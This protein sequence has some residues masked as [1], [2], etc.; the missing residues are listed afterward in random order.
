MS[1]EGMSA[2]YVGA[3][4][5]LGRLSAEE[6]RQLQR[7]VSR[8]VQRIGLDELEIRRRRTAGVA[9]PRRLQAGGR[10]IEPVGSPGR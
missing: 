7:E 5:I 4:N 10:S 8:R 6:L 2:L 9:S 3:L 1:A